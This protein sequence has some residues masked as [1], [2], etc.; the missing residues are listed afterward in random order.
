MYTLYSPPF[1]VLSSSCIQHL[2]PPLLPLLPPPTVRGSCW[3]EIC[4]FRRDPEHA[5]QGNGTL[6]FASG[7]GECGS[8]HSRIKLRRRLGA[9]LFLGPCQQVF[10]NALRLITRR[11]LIVGPALCGDRTDRCCDRRR[12]AV[13]DTLKSI[14]EPKSVERRARPSLGSETG[15]WTRACICGRRLV[16]LCNCLARESCSVTSSIRARSS[17]PWH[18][19]ARRSSHVASRHRHA[20]EPQ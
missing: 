10:P 11:A 18:D 17:V 9:R 3:L 8:D 1:S 14:L 4:R 2:P 15:D 13:S 19:A 20:A 12:H 7:C 6:Q 16:V 5:V